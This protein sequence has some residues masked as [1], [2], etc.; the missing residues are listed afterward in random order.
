MWFDY[1]EVDVDV[2]WLGCYLGDGVGDVF[3]D[4]WFGD[5]GVDGVG[6]FVVAVEVYE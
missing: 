2:G 6:L 3:G 1:Y 5:I 4:E